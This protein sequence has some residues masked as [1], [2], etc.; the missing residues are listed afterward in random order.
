LPVPQP[1]NIGQDSTGGPSD[2]AGPIHNDVIPPDSGPG[3]IK[4]MQ[5]RRRRRRK[6]LPEPPVPTFIMVS[7]G[8]YI[9]AE[10]P[11]PPL[12]ETAG[13]AVEDS[14]AP[15]TVDPAKDVPPVEGSFPEAGEDHE[16]RVI[17]SPGPPG[18][19]P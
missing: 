12:H 15:E 11:A 7:P 3:P 4:K 18:D 5:E 1:A 8:R 10:P 19:E 2:P 14:S 13:G 9:R 16:D 6:A 17:G